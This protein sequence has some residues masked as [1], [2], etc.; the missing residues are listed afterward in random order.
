M[1]IRPKD[2]KF[3]ELILFISERSEGDPRF[4][5]AKLNK[6]LFNCDFLAFRMW[7]NSITGQEYEKCSDGPAPRRIGAVRKMLVGRGELAIRKTGPYSQ[8]TDKTFALRPADLKG[9]TA[10]EIDLV[11]R[12]IFENRE[13]DATQVRNL[14]EEICGWEKAADSET[15][16]YEIA[17]LSRRPPT[18]KE[19]LRALQDLPRAKAFFAAK[20]EVML[21]DA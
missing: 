12:M 14:G 1:T 19:R 15:I 10:P 11:N 20:K 18:E 21:T 6:L 17:F 7:R 5:A 13:H 2:R 16:P 3:A 4:G 9:F 8:P